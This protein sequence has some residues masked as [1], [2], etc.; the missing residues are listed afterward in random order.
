MNRAYSSYF[1]ALLLFGSNGVI[2]SYI[3]LNS[4]EIVYLRS[5]LGGGSLLALY[6]LTG[7]R[8]TALQ[9][10]RDLLFIA[11]SGISMVADWL[12][13]FEA[14][15]QIGVSMGMIINYFGPAIVVALS[16]LLFKERLTRSKWVSLAAALTGVFLI[17]GQTAGSHSG[18][19]VACA[20]LSAISYALMV[21]CNKKAS[22]VQGLE[23]ATL[24][25][26]FALMTV[27]VFVWI[28]QGISI[29][30]A[31]GDWFP[32]LWLGLVNTGA[33]CYFYFSSIGR[34]PAQTVAICGYA[35][36]V[37]AVLFSV[38]IL[39]EAMLP[40]Q[41]LGAVL[42]IGGALIGIGLVGSK[43]HILYSK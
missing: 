7:H 20:I 9:H 10:K 34:L 27:A 41:I 19:G 1:L 15:A 28:K 33:G 26:L 13:L 8:M 31:A 40:L 23:N 25:L 36:P 21:I 39:H 17:S 29:E 12:F 16:P 5:M 35:E 14:Y 3:H 18:W 32:I 4:Y 30:I 38:I 24:Q 11:L 6:F 42:I 22:H 43:K 37:S 2:A